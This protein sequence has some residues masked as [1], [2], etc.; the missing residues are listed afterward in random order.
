MDQEDSSRMPIE[1]QER[2]LRIRSESQPSSI[3]GSVGATTIDRDRDA[4]TD[5]GD[6]IQVFCRFRPFMRY[7][8]SGEDKKTKCCVAFHKSGKNALLKHGV[9]KPSKYDFDRVFQPSS[10]QENIFDVV[11]ASIV[12]GM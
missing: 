9:D 1:E 2:M 4:V 10:T 8:L 7:E 3:V 6:N 12:Q 5:F 11:G